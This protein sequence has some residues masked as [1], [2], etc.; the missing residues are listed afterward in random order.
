MKEVNQ[1][2]LSNVIGA[3]GALCPIV[4]WLALSVPERADA[5]F[6][7]YGLYVLFGVLLAGVI[8]PTAAALAGS[9]RWLIVTAFGL[10]TLVLFF[11]GEGQ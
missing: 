3:V 1:R 5:L 8:L 4:T 11:I 7:P 10:I 6:R 2:R 9:K